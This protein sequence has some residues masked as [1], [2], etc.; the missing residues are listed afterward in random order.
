M[1]LTRSGFL[2]VLLAAKRITHQK[3][4]HKEI[5]VFPYLVI[6]K[7]RAARVLIVIVPVEVRKA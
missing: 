2:K 7:L 3:A 1:S 6:T 4:A 5:E